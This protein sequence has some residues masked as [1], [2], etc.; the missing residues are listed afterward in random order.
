M[1]EYRWLVIGVLLLGLAMFLGAL[2]WNHRLRRYEFENR[3]VGG[4][5]QFKSYGASL[6]HRFQ[7]SLLVL[8]GVTGLFAVAGG[9][10]MFMI[11]YVID[12]K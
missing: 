7:R 4:V 5:V 6:A 1:D 10:F 3:T 8:V 9:L 12:W 11:L 2:F